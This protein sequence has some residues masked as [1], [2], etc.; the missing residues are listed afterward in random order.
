MKK[1]KLLVI[2][3]LCTFM[4]SSCSAF[5][6]TMET[7]AVDDVFEEET[8]EEEDSD[9]W[10]DETEETN[11][12]SDYKYGQFPQAPWQIKETVIYDE[13]NIT[14]TAKELLTYNGKQSY[15]V[16]SCWVE[17]NS[18]HN[19]TLTESQL[20]VNGV[21]YR[22]TLPEVVSIPA[23][24]KETY[25]AMAQADYLSALGITDI[26]SIDLKLL[27]LN[28]NN[29]TQFETD[30]VNI[31]TNY[32][33]Q[34]EEPYLVGGTVIADNECL[35]ASVKI[36]ETED[37]NF[38]EIFAL[39]RSDKNM[40][41]ITPTLVFGTGSLPTGIRFD[42]L[43]N[44]AIVLLYD[45]NTPMIINANGGAFPDG[46]DISFGYRFLKTSE[47][48]WVSETGHIDITVDQKPYIEN[49]G[50]SFGEEED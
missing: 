32:F 41:V 14:I 36:H 19:I 50:D 22:M 28:D 10:E 21:D 23:G 13:D 38:L 37:A 2:P 3:V 31:K 44:K 48:D 17:N 4:F 46:V 25:Y 29:A 43:P 35:L 33:G 5:L 1:L 26:G 18:K 40:R 9:D 39:N 12:E 42:V 45:L 24:S 16:V 8:E 47:Y 30:L 34:T 7:K 20:F 49:M 11:D 27:A 6:N 15:Y